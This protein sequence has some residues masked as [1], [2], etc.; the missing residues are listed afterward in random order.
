MEVE[1][2]G[3]FGAAGEPARNV[4][5]RARIAGKAAAVDLEALARHAD[6]VAEIQNT[7]RVPTPVALEFVE[8][9]TV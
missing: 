1:V 7:L 5:Y 4:T 2:R 6:T 3:N 9:V 8:V